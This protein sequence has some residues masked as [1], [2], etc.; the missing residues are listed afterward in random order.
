MWVVC[1]NTSTVTVFHNALTWQNTKELKISV[2]MM[3]LESAPLMFRSL[4]PP[5][6][7]A[8]ST[9]SWYKLCPMIF[10]HMTLVMKLSPFRTGGLFIISSF[11]G[12]VASAKA[13]NVS[14]IILTHNSC[15]AVRGALPVTEEQNIS[16][17]LEIMENHLMEIHS[18]RWIL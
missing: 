7:R 9:N 6:M 11:G 5:N 12:S 10:L 15:T 13:P 3:D 16:T 17:V 4:S 8:P 18:I 14:M 2:F 1:G